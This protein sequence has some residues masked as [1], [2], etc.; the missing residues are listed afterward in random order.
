MRRYAIAAGL[1]AVA[2]V[3]I[4]GGRQLAL[5]GQENSAAGHAFTLSGSVDGLA[6]GKPAPLR[7]TVANP[8]SQPIRLTSATA[9][10]R[11]AS[12]VCPAS[13]LTIK[14]FSGTP[15]TIVA[16]RS[17]AVIELT[18][19][20]SAQAPEACKKVSFPLTYAGQAEQWH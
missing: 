1:T 18:V 8:D 5:A 7:L 16:A 20:L 14:A 9:T 11:S 4:L 19:T 12:S 10:P 6:P 2:A 13:L 17:R 15:E 3:G